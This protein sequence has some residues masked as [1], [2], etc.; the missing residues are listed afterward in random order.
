MSTTRAR[1]QLTYLGFAGLYPL[2]GSRSL[3]T[4][5]IESKDPTTGAPLSSYTGS[6]GFGA[7]YRTPMA[8]GAFGGVALVPFPG[9]EEQPRIFATSNGYYRVNPK[10]DLYHFALIDLIAAS[11]AQVTNLSAGLNVK[12]TERLRMTASYNRVD[13]DSLNIQAQAFLDTPQ[14]NPV[15][16]NNLFLQR[17]A[18]N[19]ARGSISAGLGDNER[20]EITIASTYRSRPGFNLTTVGATATTFALPA[21]TGVPRSTA[22][23][24]DRYSIKGARIGVDAVET[25]GVGDVAYQRDEF[26]AYRAFAARDLDSGHG[27]WEAE[28]SYASNKD[29]DGAGAVCNSA[30]DPVNCFGS[31]SSTVLSA[32]GTLY[33][34]FNRDWFLISSAYLSHTVITVATMPA[35]TA[36]NGFTGYLRFSHRF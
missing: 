20:F 26:T 16:Q 11:G 36:I 34:R 15:I 25:F 32:G 18:T 7:A 2:R 22:R 33:Y 27:E 30:I 9:E 19:Q 12:P 8:Y 10:L 5:Y 17:L 31:T 6:A 4:D 35:D 24:L 14:A 21:A 13:T 28:V 1:I 23:S 29:T 3:T